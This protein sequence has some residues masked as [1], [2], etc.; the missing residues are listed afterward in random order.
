MPTYLYAAIVGYFIGS[1]PTAYIAGR[2]SGIDIRKVGSGNVGATNVARILGKR[3]GYLV[4]FVDLAKGFAGVKSAEAL[5]YSTFLNPRSVDFCAV[6]GATFAVIGH[7]YPI[8]LRFKG[9]K[10]VATSIG[11]VFTLNWIPALVVG[12]LWLVI[13]QT[14]RYVSLASI[15]AA[16]CLPITIAVMFFLEQI[17]TPLLLYF[18]LCLAAIVVFRHRSNIS[19]LLRG[20]E[21]RIVRK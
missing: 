10:G 15:A 5:A 2:L 20:T 8:W 9:G 18:S 21:P 6:L 4:F 17:P 14:T 16:I 3:T 7:S 12:V 13:F 19:R 11:A 1:F